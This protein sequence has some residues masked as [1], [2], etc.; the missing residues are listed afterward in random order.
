VC[1]QDLVC[2]LSCVFV[3]GSSLPLLSLIVSLFGFC[4]PHDP[5]FESRL[6]VIRLCLYD[7]RSSL[8][9]PWRLFSCRLG[10]PVCCFIFPGSICW[11]CLT[12]S[13]ALTSLL[14]S[15]PVGDP[16][17]SVPCGTSVS[18]ATPTSSPGAVALT[19]P[20]PHKP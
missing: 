14:T 12:T 15:G 2:W 7:I 1:S 20:V 18:C 4:L 3:R 8:A 6:Q 5:S 13:L 17:C 9:S 19:L 10:R 16:R 11:T